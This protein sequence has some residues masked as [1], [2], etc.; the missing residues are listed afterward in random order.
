VAGDVLRA[1]KAAKEIYLERLAAN[2]PQDSDDRSVVMHQGMGMDDP[3]P[4]GFERNRKSIEALAEW[5]HLERT[6]PTKMKPEDLFVHTP[7]ME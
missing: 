6:I 3:L 1:F 7:E 2:G 5:A 4:F